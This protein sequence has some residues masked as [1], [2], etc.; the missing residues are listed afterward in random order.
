MNF[1]KTIGRRIIFPIVISTHSELLL[2]AFTKNKLLILNYHG[3]VKKSD[4]KISPNHLS[5]EQFTKHI[6]YLS[7]NFNIVSLTDIFSIHQQKLSVDKKTI[8]ITFDDGYENNFLNAFPVLQKFSAPAT[9]FVTAQAVENSSEPLWYDALDISKSGLRWE[10]FKLDERIL[11]NQEFKPLLNSSSFSEFKNKL[12]NLPAIKK[13]EVFRS[14]LPSEVLENS[15]NS[16]D[17][18]YWKLLSNEQMRTLAGSGLIEIGSHGYS[19]TNLDILPLD[20]LNVEL[21]RSRKLLETVIQKKV[22]SLAFPDGAYNEKVKMA[23]R[24]AGYTHLCAVN[25]RWPNDQL[26]NSILPR[27]SISNT[28]TFESVMIQIHRAFKYSGF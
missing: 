24:E 27:L 10:E 2:S 17:S 23:S 21:V 5:L 19:H 4:P 20:E 15:K 28:T 16:T 13:A 7:K 8:A 12:K 3:V 6:Q 14:L 11:N 9:I 22:I 26:D 18:E 1:I 25:Y